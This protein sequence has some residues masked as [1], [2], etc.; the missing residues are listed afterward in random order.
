MQSFLTT[1]FTFSS[2]PVGLFAVFAISTLLLSVGAALI[3][4]AI[5]IT[6]AFLFVLPILFVTTSTATVV[7]ASTVSFYVICNWLY[8]TIY[9][10]SS[11]DIQFKQTRG[12]ALEL[13]REIDQ[14][15]AQE[16]QS[17][18][19]G[20]KKEIDNVSHD[21]KQITN[22]GINTVQD[23]YYSAKESAQNGYGQLKDA[24]N[25]TSDDAQRTAA[26]AKESIFKDDGVVDGVKAK[27]NRLG[28]NMKESPLAHDANAH[29][30]TK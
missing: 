9:K 23:N 13:K 17:Y 2:V 4:S 18:V 5:V 10:D 6:S 30:K 24:A 1:Q 21:V 12:R 29:L 26:S 8:T 3:F 27:G 22:N 19:N 15:G 14:N 16:A 25:A 28:H 20:A 11:I 7:W